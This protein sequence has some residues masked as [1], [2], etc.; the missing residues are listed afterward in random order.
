MI[1]NHFLKKAD[2]SHIIEKLGLKPFYDT[3]YKFA[4]VNPFNILIS[5]VVISGITGVVTLAVILSDDA[6]AYIIPG[7]IG[8]WLGK[9]V[10]YFC[11]GPFMFLG[12]WAWLKIVF[13][14]LVARKSARQDS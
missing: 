7:T 12:F 1:V 9:F 6:V 3:M 8:I 13:G 5:H 4:R 10:M 2:F 14:A 11:I